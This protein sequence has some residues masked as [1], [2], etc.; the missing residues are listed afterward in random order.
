MNE[1]KQTSWQKKLKKKSFQLGENSIELI[2]LSDAQILISQLL[3]EQR[4]ICPGLLIENKEYSQ[5]T[6]HFNLYKDI[7]NAPEP[8]TEGEVK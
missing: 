6:N 5:I 8:Q 2:K 4:E 1:N 7:L 3:K